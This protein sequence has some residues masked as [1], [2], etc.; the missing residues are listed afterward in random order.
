M[1][2]LCKGTCSVCQKN[3]E[4]KFR[5]Q[6]AEKDGDFLYFCSQS[7]VQT[8]LNADALHC[9]CTVC[10]ESFTPTLPY[11][12]QM[13]DKGPRYVCSM[14]CKSVNASKIHSSPPA[15]TPL[16]FETPTHASKVTPKH[17][18]FIPR[19][20][21]VFNHKGGT[22]KTTTSVNLAA[23]LAESGK[24]VLL[25]DADGQGNVGASL[26]I[27]GDQTLYHV[28]VHGANADEVSIPVRENLDVLTSNELLA[29]A[30][31][32][33]AGRPNR[34]RIM[35]ER[36]GDR[37]RGYDV[38]IIDCAPALSLM[39]QNALVYADSVLIPVACDYLSLV[40]TKQVLRTLRNVHELLKHDVS[41][42]GVLPTFYDHR[43]K[44]SRDAFE[45]LKKNFESRCLPPIR[46]NV[47]LKEAPSMRQHIFEYAPESNGAEDYRMLVKTIASMQGK[48]IANWASPV[49]QELQP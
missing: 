35:K 26:G 38:V 42:L 44:L 29:A 18:V 22:G 47:K 2:T 17:D 10:G 11:Q 37:V 4:V 14:L 13:T 31:L 34:D 12:S 39:N 48:S 49:G 8:S 23:G 33:I 9:D 24:K 3:F 21:A 7:C 15:H 40:G 43:N 20:I 45:S 30:E 1:D 27:R 19:R 36:L 46:V 32:Y 16:L 5:Y 25:I 6:M 41:M 28:L